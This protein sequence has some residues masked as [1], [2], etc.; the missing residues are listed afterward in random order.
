MHPYV[1][2][3]TALI[4]NPVSKE[5]QRMFFCG[6]RPD[7]DSSANQNS[8]NVLEFTM[9]V[10]LFGA[11]CAQQSC[12]TEASARTHHRCL[13][14]SVGEIFIWNWWYLRIPKQTW[15]RCCL[16]FN[17]PAQPASLFSWYIT[18]CVWLWSFIQRWKQMLW[19]WFHFIDVIFLC[20]CFVDFLNPLNPRLDFRVTLCNFSDHC[21]IN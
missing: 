3:S 19:K 10:Q 15:L 12:H 16:P 14:H 11:S 6:T 1:D 7:I 9:T 18:V 5:H 21:L 8:T 2:I 20:C 13:S 17:L 4:N